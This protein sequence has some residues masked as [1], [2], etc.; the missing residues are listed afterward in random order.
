MR[1]HSLYLSLV[2]DSSGPHAELAANTPLMHL[3]G[4]LQRAVKIS[5]RCREEETAHGRPVSSRCTAAERHS[6]PHKG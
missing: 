3:A 2:S 6:H 4:V 5:V 1:L